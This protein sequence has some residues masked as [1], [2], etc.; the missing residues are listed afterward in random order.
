MASVQRPIMDGGHRLD[1][2]ASVGIAI[3]ADSRDEADR[4]IDRA[5]IAMYRAKQHGQG[6]VAFF[7][8][9]SVAG[10]LARRAIGDDLRHALARD[11]FLMHFQPI[12]DMITGEAIAYEALLRW[13]HP[14]RGILPAVDFFDQV[15]TNVDVDA[16]SAWVIDQ[17]VGAIAQQQGPP[18]DGA[19]SAVFINASPQQ[20]TDRLVSHLAEALT[21]Y[22]VPGGSVCVEMT[23][24]GLFDDDAHLAVIEQV[25]ALGCRLAL[26]DFGTG[27]SSM[28]RLATYPI[29]TVK[30]DRSFVAGLGVRE[31]STRRSSSRSS[32]WRRCWGA[33]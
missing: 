20:L 14:E 33:T 16:L 11:E 5:D 15:A 19:P 25:R 27:Q 29:D 24:S 21:R 6:R 2:T 28:S 9:A 32:D 22:D 17:A 23:E 31:T 8:D 12:V 7:D 30:I 4:L 18:R 3:S 13:N 10:T 26:D 1:I